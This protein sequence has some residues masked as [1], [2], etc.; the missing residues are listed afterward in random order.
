MT[1][2]LSPIFGIII[3]LNLVF[4]GFVMAFIAPKPARAPHNL[5]T[6]LGWKKPGYA[7]I[8][9]GIVYARFTQVAGR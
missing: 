8:V 3:G 6:W 2:A 4:A 1:P 7:L 5:L 9:A